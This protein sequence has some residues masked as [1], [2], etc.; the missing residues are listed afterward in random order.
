MYTVYKGFTD[1]FEDD[2]FIPVER[3]ERYSYIQQALER[4]QAIVLASKK[5]TGAAVYR[6]HRL[7]MHYIGSLQEGLSCCDHRGRGNGYSA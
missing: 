5:P 6:G 7:L 4:A 3:L 1:I 2:G